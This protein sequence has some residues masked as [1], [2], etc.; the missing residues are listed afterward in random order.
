[1]E[2]ED[3]VTIEENFVSIEEVEEYQ[4]KAFLLENN[5]KNFVIRMLDEIREKKQNKSIKES[6]EALM[7]KQ[8]EKEQ[9]VRTKIRKMILRKYEEEAAAD[10]KED[11]ENPV[12]QNEHDQ[13][14]EEQEANDVPGYDPLY[15]RVDMNLDR[16]LKMMT[17]HSQAVDSIERKLEV[18]SSKRVRQT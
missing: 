17:G 14:I 16:L 2:P 8:Y 11:P 4:R 9:K 15:N 6:V 3:R 5:L 7:S 13:A 12:N 10:G 18:L 1:M